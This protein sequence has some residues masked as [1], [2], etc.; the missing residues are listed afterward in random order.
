MVNSEYRPWRRMRKLD[1]APVICLL[2]LVLS[3]ADSRALPSR[4]GDMDEDGIAS[5][6]DLVRILNHIHGRV[7]FQESRISF[8]DLNRD[9]LV[10]T[11]DV[12]QVADA[13]VASLALAEIDFR[14]QLS[15]T[16]PFTDRDRFTFAGTNF[17]RTRVRLSSSS[18]SFETESDSAGAFSFDLPLAI[19]QS[20]EFYL[21]GFDA[22]GSLLSRLPIVVLQDSQGP[23]LAVT[24]PDNSW[25]TSSDSIVVCGQL[26]DTLTGHLGMAATVAGV[27]AEVHSGD[28]LNGS[29]KSSPVSL[30]LGANVIPIRAID[31]AGN[32]TSL[33]LTVT[34]IA[35]G[36]FR[37]EKVIG[38]DQTS[39]IGEYLPD[40]VVV[41]LVGP[42]GVPL[43]GKAVVF[44]IVGG[45]GGI[46]MVG[47]TDDLATIQAVTNNAGM[48]SVR[49]KMGVVAGKGNH[50]LRVTSRDL[51][52]G[53][54][55]VASAEPKASVRLYA[56]SRD[57][58]KGVAGARLS[59]PLRVWVND[60]G[61]ALAGRSVK[62]SVVSGAGKVNG[63][64][65]FT[66]SSGIAG[67]A[68]V[69]FTF[70]PS[71]GGNTIAVSA[72]GEANTTL[73]F[74]HEG[75]LENQQLATSL[76]GLVMTPF[77]EAISGA[78]LELLIEGM[79]FGPVTSDDSGAFAFEA[80]NSGA[81]ELQVWLPNGSTSQVSPNTPI[82]KRDLLLTHG[83]VNALDQALI[84]PMTLNRSTVAYDGASELRLVLPGNEGFSMVIP[85]GAVQT[86]DGGNPSLASPIPFSLTQIP[87]SSLPARPANG[88]TPRIA[89]LLEP[90]DIVFTTTPSLT[91]PDLAGLNG[92]ASIGVFGMNQRGKRFDR[93]TSLTAVGSPIDYRN[94]I[95]LGRIP[96]G[97]A[98]VSAGYQSG[99]ATVASTS[100]I[101]PSASE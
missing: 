89:W 65:E 87:T 79:R 43:A 91:V 18:G 2:A 10:N 21:A 28:G 7:P 75:V 15:P 73:V 94:S 52:D 45:V 36:D 6:H 9:G 14:P 70:G 66:V 80:L 20:Q 100:P 11:L 92:A 3:I 30:N 93:L 38:D 23:E 61:N 58:Q 96:A 72:L 83:L 47:S 35:A 78:R 34:R 27:A 67:F 19:G 64:D 33:D 25:S 90:S 40:S 42:S 98:F 5:I 17:P 48:V 74:T 82:V 81:A 16:V 86:R 44:E 31:A 12:D 8:A 24:F 55:F 49:W 13:I 63:Q 37:L 97:F 41:R 59:E 56:A 53:V 39:V 69:Q 26:S 57:G 76:R 95:R 1:P 51:G 62:F 88:E 29:F 85:A 71:A 77:F 84:L 4:L 60:G 32:A 22:S 68:E 46:S 99:R 101:S 50:L 54:V